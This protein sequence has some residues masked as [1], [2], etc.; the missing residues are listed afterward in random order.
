[1]V[2]AYSNST[3]QTAATN[4]IIGLAK[5]AMSSNATSDWNNFFTALVSG[6][7]KV[8]IS[9]PTQDPGGLRGLARP[10]SC[11]IPLF[12]RQPAGLRRHAPERPGQRD[13]SSAADLVAPLQAGDIQ[14]LFIYKSAATTDGL[15]LHHP[16]PHVNLGT[17]SLASFYSKFSY[18][19][20][21]GVT[22]GRP[23]VICI[24]IPL[25]VVNTAEAL[26][27]VPYVVKNANSLA[28]FGLVPLSPCLLYENTPPPVAIQA[29][30][31]QGLAVQQRSA[32]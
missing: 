32:P 23:I 12:Q 10:R 20:S 4:N 11:R 25:S 2:L 16:E 13:R 28:T 26:Q 17:A 24:T 14:F 8:G 19:D 27:F 7:V 15:N 9:A 29:L 22:K 21:A 1:M 5:T 3:T 6:T 31:T 30:I 18:T